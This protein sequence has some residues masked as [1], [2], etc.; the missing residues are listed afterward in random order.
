MT[1]PEQTALSRKAR[2]WLAAIVVVYFASR[3]IF[4]K[5]YGLFSDEA[6]YLRWAANVGA[7][8]ESWFHP[9]ADGK[10]PLFIWMLALAQ[11]IISDPLVAGRLLAV[12][13]GFVALLGLFTLARLL[14]D[15]RTALLAAALYLIHP[16]SIVHDRMALFDTPLTAFTLWGLVAMIWL[17]RE[18]RATRDRALLVSLLFAVAYMMKSTGA[19]LLVFAPIAFLLYTPREE[20]R[21]RVE[22]LRLL[23]YFPVIVAL[24]FLLLGRAM[25]AG[26]YS[27]FRYFLVTPREL[28]DLPF[29]LWLYNLDNVWSY[30]DLYWGVPAG[31]LAFVGLWRLERAGR[32]RDAL[33]L[34]LWAATGLAFYCFLTK[35]WFSRYLL[36]NITPMLAPAAAGFLW[37]AGWLRRAMTTRE[38][39]AP[40]ALPT[41]TLAF[42]ACFLVSIEFAA[43]SMFSPYKA[44]FALEDHNQYVSAASAGS[45]FDE[46]V[47]FLEEETAGT[48]TCFL[49]ADHIGLIPDGLRLYLPE[50]PNR[51]YID[52][53]RWSKQLVAYV[54]WPGWRNIIVVGEASYPGP[55]LCDQ[56]YEDPDFA[57]LAEYIN[58][59][60]Y[61]TRTW[62]AEWQPEEGA[63]AVGPELPIE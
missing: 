41:Q 42:I 35:A 39:R 23:V 31:A 7:S 8:F 48:R 54:A 15:E 29:R 12:A 6:I 60:L 28:I 2:L 4:L 62:I 26:G 1:Q 40:L 9:L 61:R 30:F 24:V 52:V 45:R 63:P 50:S 14:Y 13:F 10:N 3:L 27:L 53:P 46:M 57:L 11:S 19:Q 22:T 38:D 5:A 37:L 33:F 17:F 25:E 56:F 18:R 16:L 44:V 59:P 20:R 36:P 55:T 43:F 32:W 58:P 34:A 51:R 49:V 47:D 21:E